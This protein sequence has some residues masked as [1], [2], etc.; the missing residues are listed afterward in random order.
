MSNAQQEPTME[1]I[2]ASIR[3]IIS[4][5]E[6][7]GG[8][9]AEAA[10]EAPDAALAAEPEADEPEQIPADPEPEPEAVV[11]PEPEPEPEMDPEPVAAEEDVLELTEV[12]E[13]EPQSEETPP[14]PEESEEPEA[15]ATDD[16]LMFEEAAEDP[17]AEPEP[18]EAEGPDLISDTAA[19][20]TASA[21]AAL[22]SNI[23][24]NRSTEGL[25]LE[26]I[27]R[28]TLRPML[29]QWLDDNLPGIVEEKVQAE[30]E[31]VA[32]RRR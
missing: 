14:E 30:I 27:V 25:T 29:K 9:T 31:R 23:A 4:E 28:E 8:E 26:D 5:D 18:V 19:A 17:V 2:L 7:E 32:R 24:V 21:F 13:D 22:S 11:E 16:D 3:R 6:E 20:A 10:D 15:E 12:V 1:E